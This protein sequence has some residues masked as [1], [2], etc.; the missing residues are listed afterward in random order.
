MVN[1]RAKGARGERELAHELTRILGCKALRGQ[2]FSGSPDSPDV[3][4]NLNGLHI[5]CKR[6]ETFNLYKSLRQAIKDA[7][8]TE[9]PCVIHKKNR[10]DWVVVVRL[11]DLKRFAE[12]IDSIGKDIPQF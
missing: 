1:S 4:T 5:E 2:Q 12:I 7:G 6:V 11:T 3:V 10:E 9:I 8:D